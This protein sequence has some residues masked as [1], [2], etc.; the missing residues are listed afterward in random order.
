MSAQTTEFD[1]VVILTNAFGRAIA[2]ALGDNAGAADA[3]IAPNKRPELGDF[4]CNAAMPLAKRLG[5]PPRTVASKIL[6]ALEPVPIIEPL[7]DADIAG[8][9]F[10]NIRLRPEAIGELLAAFDTPALGLVCE[11]E[12]ETVVVDLCGVNLAKQMHVGHLRSMIIGDALARI[13]ER[14]GNRTIRQNHVGDWGLP[15]AMVTHKLQEEVDSGRMRLDAVTLDDLDRLYKEAQR[16]CTADTR[17][18]AAARRWRMGPKAE[19][20]LEAQVTGAEEALADAKQT[21]LRLQRQEPATVRIWRSIADIT[22]A[23]CLKVSEQLGVRLSA[24]DAAGES[25]YAAELA[26]IAEDLVSRGVAEMS[27]GALV[28]KVEGLDQPCLIKK[29]DGGF[30]YA[31]TDMA[32]IRR[33]VQQFGADRVIYCVDSRQSLHFAQVFG[34][35]RRSGYAT[36]PGASTPS[37]L[38]H[39]ANGMVLGEDH[40]PFKTRSGENVKLADLISEAME[41]AGNV[42]AA[43]SRDLPADEVAAIA[44]AVGV[45]AI[46]YADLSNDRIKDYVFSFDRM[47]S[48]EGNTGPYLLYAL[49]RIRSIFRKAQERGIGF[50]RHAPILPSAPAERALALVLLRYPETVRA[51]AKH[52][53]PHR[54]CGL[55]YELATAFSTFF[56]ACPVLASEGATRAGRLRLCD[57]TARVLADGLTTLGIP[58]LERM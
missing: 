15:I 4:Q 28:V 50:D 31:T 32:A 46:K 42:V 57:I 58:T 13:F 20:E 34:A 39:A 44:R 16:D 38:E 33:R 27:E 35:A 7:T 55:L 45:A 40:R 29:S 25:S 19:A 52:L 10:I 36:K 22:M 21:L 24:E 47:L 49:V 2:Q 30:L 41:R 6:R 11:G 5:E 8:P 14:L 54:L 9:G 53:E 1:P 51:A 48:F 18:L 43:K 17:G 12:P 37:R 23:E 56:D 26:G 3:M